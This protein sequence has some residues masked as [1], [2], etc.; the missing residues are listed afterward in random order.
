MNPRKDRDMQIDI[1]DNLLDN[2]ERAVAEKMRTGHADEARYE[3]AARVAN[4]TPPVDEDFQKALRARILTELTKNP[5]TTISLRGI[6]NNENVAALSIARSRGMETSATDSFSEEKKQTMTIKE[7]AHP[8][9]LWQLSLVGVV[10]ILVLV[11]AFTVSQHIRVGEP[12]MRGESPAAPTLQLAAG[13]VD[14]LIHKLNLDPTPRT[15]I[16]FP[17]GYAET[18]AKRI[19]H[20]VIPLVVDGDLAPTAIQAALGTALPSSGLVDVILVNHEATDTTQVRTALEQQ[21]YRLYRPGEDT[22][23]VFGALEHSQFIVGPQDAPMEPIGAIFESGIELVA[24]S[25]PDAPQPGTPLPLAFDWRV[26]EPAN[27]S[28]L[29]FVHIIHND[30]RLMAQWDAIPGNELF[31]AEGWEPGDVVR[32]QFALLLPPELPAG[33]YEVQVGIYSSITNLRY[34]LIEPEENVYI[35]VHQFTLGE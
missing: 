19:Q 17:A 15:V 31:S 10:T 1:R 16:V 7:R 35:V 20:Q 3:F 29:M 9:N 18:L 8:I 5:E 21:L 32:N 24:G 30:G 23:E 14:A 26:M 28:L 6:T 27:D 25:V 2:V 13:D 34:R 4:A 11:L 12:E 33:D 22:T